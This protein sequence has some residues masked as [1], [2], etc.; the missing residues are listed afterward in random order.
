[1]SQPLNIFALVGC[2]SEAEFADNLVAASLK[3]T[4]EEIDWLERGEEELEKT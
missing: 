4:A 3:L 2:R 1:M